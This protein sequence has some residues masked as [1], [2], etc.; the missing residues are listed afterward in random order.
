MPVAP[1]LPVAAVD[2]VDV[3]PVVAEVDEVLP[4]SV[5]TGTIVDDVSLLA[6]D[7][8]PLVSDAVELVSL[9][10]SSLLLQANISIA[11]RAAALIHFMC[12]SYHS[13]ELPFIRA[14]I[15]A[16]SM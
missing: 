5:G 7:A 9:V 8:V 15:L 12:S 10:V 14:M 1:V 2:V 4:V 11:A 3:V 6:A 16:T 13:H